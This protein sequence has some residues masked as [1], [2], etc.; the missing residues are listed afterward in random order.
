[1]S[2]GS[3]SS[4]A[5]SSKAFHFAAGLGSG[6]LSAILLQP[7]DLL[8]TRVQ[9]S[10]S[11]S[12]LST[13]RS[14]AQRS[15]N[16]ISAFWRGTVPSTLRTGFGSAIYFSTLNTIR[17]H[18]AAPL[19]TL[20][21]SAGGKD[22]GGRRRG[23]SSSS[24]SLPKLSNTANLASGA[25]AR[26][27]AGM[28]LMPLTVI[29]V[30]YE[31]NLYAYTSLAG[32]VTDIYRTERLRGFFAGF[33]ATAVRDAPYAGLYVLFYEQFKKRLSSFFHKD[34]QDTDGHNGKNHD[35]RAMKTSLSASINFS[36][37]ALASATCSF[38]TNPFDAIKTRIQLQPLN[39]TNTLQ[40]GRRMVVE[41]GFRSLYDGLALRMARKAMSSA[42]AWML[43]EELIRRAETT[44]NNH[45]N[46]E[47]KG[48]L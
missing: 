39:Y 35:M 17:Q 19:S 38:L 37:G 9:Q 34:G 27:F 22:G 32:A 26:A 48:H 12:V 23:Y 11:Q 45:R 20:T 4:N 42:L 24:S 10:D 44:W 43:Y 2:N 47:G 16:A 18:V 25:V 33:G 46:E 6:T 29:K 21:V 40:A 5:S 41:E 15:P 28:V 7:I 30:R 1:M 3:R 13:I 8:K 31:S 36:S 14:I